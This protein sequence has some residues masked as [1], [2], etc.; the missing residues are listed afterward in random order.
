MTTK[1]QRAAQ[2]RYNH[3]RIEMIM[4]HSGIEEFGRGET[5][6][7]AILDAIVNSGVTREWIQDQVARGMQA[8]TSGVG[9]VFEKCDDE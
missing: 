8:K 7:A 6:E 2:A 3:R 9:L 5:E 4:L 1:A